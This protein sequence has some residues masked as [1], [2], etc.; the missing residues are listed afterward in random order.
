MID[1]FKRLTVIML[2]GTGCIVAV[3]VINLIIAL[4]IMFVAI[5]SGNSPLYFTT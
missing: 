5:L 4:I 1:L 3:A 2:S